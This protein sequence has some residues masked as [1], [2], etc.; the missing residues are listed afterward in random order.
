MPN[1]RKSDSVAIMNPF[2]KI[3]GAG[4]DFI[5]FDETA[6]PPRRW[7]N[8]GIVRTLCDRHF[9]IGADG[10]ICL[11]RL[12]G[13]D[14]FSWEFYNS[15]G[16]DADMCGNAAR[17][18]GAYCYAKFNT[19]EISLRT[20]SGEVKIRKVSYRADW[21]AVEL[22][23]PI[24][25]ALPPVGGSENTLGAQLIASVQGR[26]LDSGVPHLVFLK[27]DFQLP[28]EEDRRFCKDLRAKLTAQGISCNITLVGPAQNQIYPMASF[29]RGVEDFT[30]ACGT[31]AVAG[32]YFVYKSVG[33][34]ERLTSQVMCAMPGGQLEVEFT[35][36]KN[37]ATLFGP[38]HVVFHGEVRL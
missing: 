19:Q 18:V 15:D 8:V 10:V 29:E 12:D 2:V 33:D 13:V 20:G 37:K 9:G 11:R 31:G 34:G 25:V 17:A 23:L 24:D 28:T 3:E 5:L 35:P 14:A 22:R 7:L 32:A 1:L 27:E 16:S 38:A 4:N 21:Q 26:L 36:E 6:I 30:L